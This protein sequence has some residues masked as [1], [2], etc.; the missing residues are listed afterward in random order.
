MSYTFIFMIFKIL[1]LFLSLL[2]SL[3]HSS[4]H[5]LHP[6]DPLTPS[7]IS[8]VRSIIIGSKQS[9]TQ[10]LTFQYVGLEEPDKHT[11]LSWLSNQANTTTTT[12]TPPRRAF[13]IT[14]NNNQT[15][16]ITLDLSTRS[17]VSDKVYKGYGYPLMTAAEQM[18]AIELPLTYA[19]FKASVSKRGLNLSEVVCGTYSVGWFGEMN[20]KKQRRL[21]KVLCN[22]LNGTVNLYA[23]PLEG[24]TVVVDLDVMKIT[25]YDDRFTVPVPKAEGTDY[26][27]SQQKPPF[28][29]NAGRTTI[30][31]PDGPGFNITGHTIRWADWKFHL[32]FDARAGSIIS[33]ASIYDLNKEE[34]RHVL[35][36]GYISELFVPYMDPTEEWYYKT[37][38]DAGEFGLGLCTVSLEPKTD[39]PANAEFMDGYYAGQDGKPIK[40]ENAICVF[41]RYAGDIMWRHTETG[42]P[43]ETIREV[44][45]EINLVVRMVSTI[46]NYDYI[47]DWEFKQSGT[48]KVSVGLTGILE[49]R[50][51]TYTHT[52]QIK[53]DAYGTLLAENTIGVYH[54]H[55]LTFHLDLDIDEQDNSFLKSKLQT[56]KVM[57]N[58]SPRKSYWSVVKEVAKHESDARIKLGLEQTEL[59]V[60][61]PNKRTKMGNHN[62]YRLIPGFPVAP[63]LSDDDYPQIRGAFTN[64]QVWVT[65]YNKSEKWASGLYV[66]QSHGD[67][68]LAIWS[69]RNRE[70]ENKDIVLWYTLGF[71][72]VPNQED[73]P[74]MP[75]LSGAFELRPSNF[76]EN[77]PVL[78]TQSHKNVEWPNCTKT[79]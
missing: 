1:C 74:V 32:S 50:S 6:L 33:L 42:I 34:F 18:A 13:V 78:K 77:N 43:G 72:H 45:P 48:I 53:E 55:F 9:S 35:Y 40:I 49:V 47:I 4:S 29:Q 19:P 64:Y 59:L 25:E 56:T 68:T 38:F 21:V 20:K 60:V 54:D 57:D 10:N 17:I 65:P 46:G 7:E 62:G 31:Q 3:S 44:R 22:Y 66:D 2:P 75:T 16:E 41:E 73:F 69:Q 24:I 52:D 5:H 36:R 70:I 79:S 23:R 61:N 8:K 15:H 11:V 76:F 30:V 14:R 63:L 28:G 26:R 67:D 37:F 27:S 58:N 39:C 51:V 71:H 12:K